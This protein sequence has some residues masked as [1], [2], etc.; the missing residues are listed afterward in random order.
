[1]NYS[2]SKS[3]ENKLQAK[4]RFGQNFLS[5]ENII[6]KII[7][8]VQPKD[9]NILEIGPGRGALSKFLVKEAKDFKAF[10]LDKDMIACLKENKILTTNQ[11][12]EGDFLDADISQ[13]KGYT[14]VGNIPYN[15]TSD[16]I[17]KIFDYHM[18]FDNVILMVQD[19]VAQRLVAKI[20]SP[21]Y[22]KLSVTA[23]YL[24]IVKKELF[25]KN[26]CFIPA[27]KVNSAIVSFRF[28][29]QENDNYQEL[30]E[31]FKICFNSRRKKLTFALSQKF[32]KDSIAQAYRENKL[33]ENTRIQELN[34]E[35]IVN[36]FY[37]LKNK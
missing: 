19:E 8:I 7:N 13:Y 22:S 10:E 27:P 26:T 30:K 9:K 29:H 6:K 16:I 15:I 37:L 4:K 25:V 2:T 33:S 24:A 34:I 18:L 31:F 21:E 1:M 20:N 14:I 36:I 28:K 5:D 32:T 23:Q 35:Q 3:Q 11:I 17:L 12:I